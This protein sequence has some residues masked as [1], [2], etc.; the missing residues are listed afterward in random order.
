[1]NARALSQFARWGWQAQATGTRVRTCLGR[2]LEQR[3][4]AEAGESGW[5]T[6]ARRQCATLIA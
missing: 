4:W 1:M 5:W 2:R 6:R 3:M